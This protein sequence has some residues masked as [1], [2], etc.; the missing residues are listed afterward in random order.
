VQD[1]DQKKAKMSLNNCRWN[2]QKKKIQYFCDNMISLIKLVAVVIA[3]IVIV[4]AICGANA[5]RTT[6]QLQLQT[7][8]FSNSSQAVRQSGS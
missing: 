3:I 5:L 4:I 7:K 8:W 1:Y 2:S 6:S